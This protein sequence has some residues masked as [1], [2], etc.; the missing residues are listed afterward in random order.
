MRAQRIIKK[1]ISLKCYI[2]SKHGKLTEM[3]MKPFKLRIQA[4]DLCPFLGKFRLSDPKF[5]KACLDLLLWVQIPLI[6]VVKWW[7]PEKII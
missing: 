4:L 3:N 2:V 1:V 5:V 7:I 6:S